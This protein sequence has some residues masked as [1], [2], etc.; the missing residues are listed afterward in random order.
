MKNKDQVPSISQKE[1][2]VLGILLS[3]ARGEM[4]GLE[5]VGESLGLLKRGTIYVTLQRMEEKELIES[6][7]EARVKP[8][9]GIP[10]RLYRVTGLGE[11]AFNKYV[12]VHQKLTEL[13]LSG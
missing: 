10:R 6:W 1:A 5:I 8:E 11:S 2:V 4:F 9:I 12:I 3:A 7:Q 13:I